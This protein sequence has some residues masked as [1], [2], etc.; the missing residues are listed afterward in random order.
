MNVEKITRLIRQKGCEPLN[1]GEAEIE[2]LGLSDAVVDVRQYVGACLTK[3]G[4]LASGVRLKSLNGI[5]EENAEPSS[6]GCHIFPYGYV[7]IATT[8]GGNAICLDS[9]TGNAFWTDHTSYSIDE[10]KYKDQTTGD[11]IYLPFAP[12]SIPKAMALLSSNLESFF[13]DLLADKLT[14]QLGSL[15]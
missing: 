10:I 5:R 15:E 1:F 9:K 7:V 4:L 8:I 13:L 3:D 2:E 11:W 12:D 14:T 6:P